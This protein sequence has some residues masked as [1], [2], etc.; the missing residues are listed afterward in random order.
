[1]FVV[2]C[3]SPLFTSPSMSLFVTRLDFFPLSFVGAI[4]SSR[5]YSVC[6]G[7]NWFVIVPCLLFVSIRANGV[8]RVMLDSTI[9]NIRSMFLSNELFSENN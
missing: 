5:L 2:N 3:F 1:M 8:A 9:N 6:C 4:F 7:L